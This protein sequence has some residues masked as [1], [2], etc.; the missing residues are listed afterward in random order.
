MNIKQLDALFHLADKY[1]VEK[2]KGCII[3]QTENWFNSEQAET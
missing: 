3:Q 2:I 1:L